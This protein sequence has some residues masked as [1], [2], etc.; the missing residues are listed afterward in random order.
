[1]RPMRLTRLHSTP[2][3]KRLFRPLLLVG[4]FALGAC[5]VLKGPPATVL[6]ICLDGFRWDYLQQAHTPNLDRLAATGVRAEALIPVFPTTRLPNQYTLVTGLYPE[7][8]GLVADTM[9]DPVFDE[10]FI[11]D[12]EYVSTNS[13]WYGNEPIWVTARKQGR[14]TA[15]FSWPGSDAEIQGYRPRLRPITGTVTTDSARVNQILSWLDLPPTLK[16]DLIA[17]HF[18]SVAIAGRRWGP[19]SS[20][21][22]AAVEE[23]DRTMGALFEG[24]VRRQ[25]MEQIDIII[26]SDHGMAALD[27]NRVIFL[28]DYLDN[29]ADLNIITWSPV[30]GMRP[31]ME[32]S[33]LLYDSLKVAH[34]RLQVYRREEVPYRLHYTAHHRI[35]TLLAIADEGWTITTHSFSEQDTLAP[36]RGASGYDP[37]YPSMH[38]IFIARGP[39]FSHGM[40]IKPFENIHIYP[41][42]AN[43][44]RL[45]PAPNDGSADAL[46]MIRAR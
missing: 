35:P 36:D 40:V 37:R 43:L 5:G 38:G 10:T 44:L 7:N 45:D 25:I 39:S 19:E 17:A 15:V 1:M 22:I 30:L 46:K 24:L 42:L 20:E 14:N 31:S 23:I 16:P 11:P 34:P 8:H 18:D 26:L 2:T 33:A 41:L 12:A 28:D 6:L 32:L 3:L 9:Y 29:P 21:V 27:T 4:L 13:Y